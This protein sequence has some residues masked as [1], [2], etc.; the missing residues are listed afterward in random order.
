MD[1]RRYNPFYKSA[2]WMAKR[3]RVLKRDGYQ[4]RECLRY[5]RVTEATTVHHI[6]PLDENPDLK[7]D[8]NNL[9]SVCNSCHNK[10]HDR[11]NDKLSP[12]GEVWVQRIDKGLLDK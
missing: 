2:R 1:D 5:G 8:S 11:D 12:L 10:M 3:T 7:L 6:K 4:C 9:I